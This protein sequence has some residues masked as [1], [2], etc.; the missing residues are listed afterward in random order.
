MAD[1]DEVGAASASQPMAIPE[2]KVM[3]IHPQP[4][5]PIS[6]SRSG[7]WALGLTALLALAC[8][9]ASAPTIGGFI[10]PSETPSVP[11]ET[12]PTE[13]AV[14][15]LAYV[16]WSGGS[17]GIVVLDATGAGVRLSPRD[18]PRGLMMAPE[19]RS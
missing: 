10:P 1:A 3:R 11:S 8:R 5:K 16:A 2:D 19:S 9:D 12:P 14:P 17:A 15:P 7:A 18:A 4:P 13:I 6:R